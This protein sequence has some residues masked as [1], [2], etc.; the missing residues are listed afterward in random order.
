[1]NVNF[2]SLTASSIYI[3]DALGALISAPINDKWGRKTTFWFAASCILAG[4]IA[5]VVDTHYEAVLVFG[6]ILICLGMGQCTVTSLLYIGE[7]APA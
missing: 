5:Q 2:T 6:R 7:V 1:M 4:G 3:G